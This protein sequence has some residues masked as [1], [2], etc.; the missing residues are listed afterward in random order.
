MSIR[1]VD[2]GP[3]GKIPRRYLQR[4][5]PSRYMVSSR[6]TSMLKLNCFKVVK[7]YNHVSR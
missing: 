4:A 7:L 3:S 6:E 2:I 1:S 5:Y